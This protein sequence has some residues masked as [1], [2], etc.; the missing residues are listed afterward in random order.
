MRGIIEM[1]DMMDLKVSGLR[2]VDA[3]R[4]IVAEW[5]PL[6]SHIETLTAEH[7][8]SR[9]RCETLERQND[10]LRRTCERAGAEREGLARAFSKLQAT[11]QALLVEHE[12]ATT[13]LRSLQAEYESLGQERQWARE[14]L[15]AALE[16]LKP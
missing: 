16:R 11:H 5:D 12:I 1:M 8:A 14:V 4:Q 3:C 13:A 15:G 9:T 6:L 10:E 2:A 7:A